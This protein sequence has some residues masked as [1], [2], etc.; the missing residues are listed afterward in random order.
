MHGAEA[1][2]LGGLDE[3]GPPTP[4]LAQVDDGDGLA[5]AVAV[6]ARA[7]LTLQL[8][9]LQ[10]ARALGGRSDHLEHAAGVGEEQAG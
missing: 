1:Q 7:L 2:R 9:Q 6:E 8:E 3:L 10:V 5:A 4:L